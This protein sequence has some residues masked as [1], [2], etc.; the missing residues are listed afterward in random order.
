MSPAT[1][2]LKEFYNLRA[3]AAL[4]RVQAYRSDPVDGAATYFTVAHGVPRQHVDLAAL[5]A[6]VEDLEGAA[7]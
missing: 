7:T 4:H 2:S 3:R 5:R 1:Q 6:R